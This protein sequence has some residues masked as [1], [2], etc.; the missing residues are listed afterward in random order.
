M[1][2]LAVSVFLQGSINASPSGQEE[3]GADGC[4]TQ[5][6]GEDTSD[7]HGNGDTREGI[8]RRREEIE[9]W[10][11][12]EWKL[13][14]LIQSDIQTENE[15]DEE[16]RKQKITFENT[17]KELLCL[18]LE[19]RNDADGREEKSRYHGEIAGHAEVQRQAVPD[20]AQ[21]VDGRI[22]L[23]ER[24]IPEHEEWFLEDEYKQPREVYSKK[25]FESFNHIFLVLRAKVMNILG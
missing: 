11:V 24:M 8:F 21:P 12:V 15:C 6:N 7:E 4:R 20:D 5:S 17:T 16:G 1:C 25:D 14:I 10:R 22:L 9:E 23:I 13:P 19:W 18:F 3:E 2:R